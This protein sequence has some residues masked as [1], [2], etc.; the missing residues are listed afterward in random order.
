MTMTQGLAASVFRDAKLPDATMGGISSRHD[1]VYLVGEGGNV[2]VPE[3][4]RN[5]LHL[6]RRELRDGSRYVHAEPVPGRHQRQG[7]PAMGGN[8]I[9]SC[10]SRFRAL[11]PYPIP[12]HDRFEDGRQ[13]VE[14][15]AA[16]ALPVWPLE[17]P[18]E[19]I[20]VNSAKRLFDGVRRRGSNALY[21]GHIC[22]VPVLERPH[23]EWL[24]LK[25]ET[26]V[27]LGWL[28]DGYDLP[29]FTQWLRD[30]AAM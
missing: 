3:H 14:Q 30:H 2:E 21:W 16:L 15:W 6:V 19:F 17:G 5:V 27:V 29:S 4:A 13:W 20:P 12:V 28:P 18:A 25:R 9:Y 1:E 26:R 23:I 8:F 22:F 24:V 10:D 7:R 11:H